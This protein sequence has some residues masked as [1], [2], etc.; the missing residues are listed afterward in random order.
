MEIERD[1]MNRK[2]FTITEGNNEEVKLAVRQPQYEDFE[3]SD[4]IYA[5]KISSLIKENANRKLLSRQ[6]L[7]KY[8]KESGTWTTEDEMRVAELQTQVD[9]L[10]SKLKKGGIK[11]SEGRELAIQ[12][13]EKRQA[14]LQINKKRQLFDD[15]TLESFAE[16][17]KLDYLIYVST[18]Y[19]ESGKNYWDSFDDMKNDKLSEAYK[20]ASQYAMQMIYNFDPEFEKKLPENKWLKKYGYVDEDL[21]YVDRKTGERVDKSGRPLSELEAEIKKQIDNFQGEIVEETPFIDDET[22]EPIVNK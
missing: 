8:L 5:I 11:V 4:K 22:Q 15:V 18:V 20:K 19:S 14:L 16:N 17:E 10:L 1:K 6:D 9:N 12:V 21:N 2:E 13:M 3:E 7:S